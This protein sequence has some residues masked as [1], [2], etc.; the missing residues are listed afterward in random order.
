MTTTRE[1]LLMLIVVN[2]AVG[3]LFVYC[4]KCAQKSGKFACFEF[5]LNK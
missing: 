2:S 4:G 1:T 3:V 5:F